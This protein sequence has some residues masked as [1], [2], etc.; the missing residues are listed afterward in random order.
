MKYE[1]SA[2]KADLIAAA[3]KTASVYVTKE[4]PGSNDTPERILMDAGE[5]T[6]KD[7]LADYK[8]KMARYS[9]IPLDIE[10]KAMRIFPGEWTILS[11]YTGTGKTTYLRQMVCGFLKDGK[12]VFVAPLESDP[13]SY[14]I[15]LA[16]TAAGV[17]IPDERQLQCFLDTYGAQLK[18]W[19]L[20][21]V[22]NPRK[23]LASIRELCD[24]GLDVAVIDNLMMLD[25]PADDIEEQ[26]KFSALLA[27]TVH[28]KQIH[29]ILVAHPRKPLAA[30]QDPS[31]SDIA[32][33]SNIGNLA[34]NVMFIRRGP[35]GPPGMQVTPMQLW[36]LKRR[37]RIPGG[38]MG[39]IE[40]YYYG[41]QSQFHLD[42]EQRSPTFYLPAEFY[43]ATGLTEDIPEH[44]IN[45]NAFKVRDDEPVKAPWDG[46]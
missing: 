11:G 24:A 13:E 8:A 25:I 2:A 17:E 39:H 15:D 23:I 4:A 14:L 45:P 43:N 27:A 41:E 12:N 26:R 31:P 30:D 40:G 19:G 37:T 44:L 7:M 9:T 38:F 46:F 16:G 18:I 32:G 28:A 6:A 42:S 21:G 36:I 29:L 34:Y 10:G 1:D 33:S 5:R 35:Q 3:R 20:I 22:A